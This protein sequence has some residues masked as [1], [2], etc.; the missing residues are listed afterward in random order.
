M[1]IHAIEDEKWEG[2]YNAVAPEPLRL[3]DMMQVIK[4]VINPLAIIVKVPQTIIRL[5]L[6]E[7]E[8]IITDSTNVKPNRALQQGFKFE[9][10]DI[11]ET[12]KNLYGR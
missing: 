10:T 12:I 4:K 7:Q 5:M 3:K 6:G 8:A 1:Y 9:F 11:T 2:C